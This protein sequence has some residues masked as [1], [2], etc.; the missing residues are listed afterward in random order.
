MATILVV[1]HGKTLKHVFCAIT[2]QCIKK[3]IRRSES[4]L[5]TID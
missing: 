3:Y 4:N 5:L 1:V 2:D